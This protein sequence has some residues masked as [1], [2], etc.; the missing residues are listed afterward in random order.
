MEDELIKVEPDQGDLIQM[1]EP[2]DLIDITGM[3]HTENTDENQDDNQDEN[4]DDIQDENQGVDQGENE[5]DPAPDEAEN[6]GSSLI[7]LGD[8]P[9]DNA[10]TCPTQE[11]IEDEKEAIEPETVHDDQTE[12]ENEEETKEETREEG[13][14]PG[15]GG[16]GDICAEEE[17]EKDFTKMEDDS[18]EEDEPPT[19]MPDKAPA[20]EDVT[21]PQTHTASHI[22]DFT[23]IYGT[24]LGCF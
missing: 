9:A 10:D 1:E 11:Q 6:Q 16:V 7:D 22:P 14:G 3:G 19:E 20:G 23:G 17:Q 8:E 2:G 21:V 24:R 18:P 13:E 5:T 12:P 4:H 15:N